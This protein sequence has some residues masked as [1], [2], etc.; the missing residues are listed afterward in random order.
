MERWK[1][2]RRQAEKAKAKETKVEKAKAKET[3]VEKAKAKTK[4]EQSLSKAIAVVGD[5]GD[6]DKESAGTTLAMGSLGGIPSGAA[7]SGS[8]TGPNSGG[9]Q[10]IA[11]IEREDGAWVFALTTAQEVLHADVNAVDTWHQDQM[12]VDFGSAVTAVS[13]EF[14]SSFDTEATDRPKLRA[15]GGQRIGTHG[16]RCLCAT[17]TDV[18]ANKVHMMM[19]V[20]VASAL[21]VGP[22]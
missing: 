13:W 1:R 19:D 4:S 17:A 8:S 18:E 20:T 6:I 15:V 3:K 7:G 16:S 14:G 5:D 2:Q 9:D 11:G 10:I 22:E 12:I 21:P